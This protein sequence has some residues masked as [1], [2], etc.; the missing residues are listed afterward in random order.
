[1]LEQDTDLRNGADRS[2]Y[3]GHAEHGAGGPGAW[4]V[5]DGPEYGRQSVQGDDDQHEPGGVE[6]DD[7]DEDHDAAGDVVSPPTDSDVPG[8]LQWNLKQNHLKY[9]VSKSGLCLW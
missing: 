8:Y 3:P 7:P 6:P 9:R 5:L 1:M 2:E 4:P